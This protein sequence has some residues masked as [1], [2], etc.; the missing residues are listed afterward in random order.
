MPLV[1]EPPTRTLIHCTGIV[2]GTLMVL[3][4]WARVDAR[5]Y[6]PTFT[7][8]LAAAS[9]SDPRLGT[10]ANLSALLTDPPA[11][12]I[13]VVVFSDCSDCSRGKYQSLVN[14]ARN[15]GNK[16]VAV[17]LEGHD[18]IVGFQPTPNVLVRDAPGSLRLEWNVIFQPR[19]YAVRSNG[20][21]DYIQPYDVP[22]ERALAE[23]TDKVRESP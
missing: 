9:A 12:D 8:E 15:T 1:I 14:Y 23:A 5:G 6:L 19:V 22:F 16:Y 7:D 4:W 10:T 13:V 21:F 2:L 20:E 11:S 17:M 3:A 18:E